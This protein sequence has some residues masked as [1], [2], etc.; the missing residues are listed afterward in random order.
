MYVY[1]VYSTQHAGA[2][3][4]HEDGDD[5][6]KLTPLWKAAGIVSGFETTAHG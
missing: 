3:Y 4:K 5:V 2:S 6:I 1:S